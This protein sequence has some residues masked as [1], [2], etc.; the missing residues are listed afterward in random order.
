[1][2]ERVSLCSTRELAALDR[3]EARGHAVAESDRARVLADHAAASEHVGALESDF[4]VQ[5]GVLDRVD[6]A[7]AAGAR[8]ALRDAL[9]DLRAIPRERLLVSADVDEDLVASVI[10]GLDRRS[11]WDAW[12]SM[13]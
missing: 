8:D 2:R 4:Q 5:L 11:R 1:M 7:R 10:S 9:A 6:A 3:E 13:T 12:C